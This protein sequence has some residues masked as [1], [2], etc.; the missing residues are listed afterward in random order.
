[1][2]ISVLDDSERLSEFSLTTYADSQLES[3]KMHPTSNCRCHKLSAF[4]G[5]R[6]QSEANDGLS[7]G[8][9]VSSEL[10]RTATESQR[11][12]NSYLVENAN[13][14]WFCFLK[15]YSGQGIRAF[16]DTFA[17]FH[18]AT[19]FTTERTSIC[20]TNSNL[21][22]VKRFDELKPFDRSAIARSQ[23]SRLSRSLKPFQAG[24]QFN[25]S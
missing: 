9:A 20:K 18:L 6:G 19:A 8:A 3:I 15:P 13:C 22:C 12:L 17:E 24:F 4:T 10:N 16:K 14:L 5:P 1:M 23:Q 7:S 21:V 25:A 2:R 11:N